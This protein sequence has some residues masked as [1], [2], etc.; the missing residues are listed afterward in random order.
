MFTKNYYLYQ[1]CRNS[2]QQAE[3][4]HEFL[5]PGFVDT[6]G[7]S[8]SS[9]SYLA[10]T[11]NASIQVI[12]ANGLLVSSIS[13]GVGSGNTAPSIDDYNLETPITDV[14]IRSIYSS[15]YE[16]GVITFTA[17]LTITNNTT[18]LISINEIGM[19]KKIG[20]GYS[21]L[22]INYLFGRNVIDTVTI[23]AGASKTIVFE[24]IEDYAIA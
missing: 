11:S 19:F 1:A 6:D 24:L 15:S 7:N 17:T 20:N 4:V 9:N 16:N 22:N 18:S 2:H 3:N 12:A 13:F 5:T 14:D 23:D 10:G 21:S 8:T